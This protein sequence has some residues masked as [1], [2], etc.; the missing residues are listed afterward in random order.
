[1]FSEENASLI[2]DEDFTFKYNDNTV[3]GFTTQGTYKNI[4]I[5]L[6][7]NN[8]ILASNNTNGTVIIDEK[9]VAPTVPPV[10]VEPTQ[11]PETPTVPQIDEQTL[12]H[13]NRVIAAVTTPTLTTP[14][15]SASTPAI[16]P[17]PTISV[18]TPNGQTNNLFIVATPMQNQPTTLIS[19][20]SIKASN[21]TTTSTRILVD[22]NSNLFMV[23]EG[24]KLPEGVDQL[25]F[26]SNVP[27]GTVE[28]TTNEEN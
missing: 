22:G 17:S 13:I 12:S 7:S 11:E 19:L 24:Q 10:I 4:S 28:P 16:T 27:S 6:L 5:G 23:D 9:Y 1:M 14:V 8:F 2:Q 25:L 20:N 15:I 21:P 18:Q 3:T 26:I